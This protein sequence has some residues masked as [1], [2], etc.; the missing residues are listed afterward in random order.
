MSIEENNFYKSAVEK[1]DKED[2]QGVI[3][4]YSKAIQWIPSDQLKNTF[5]DVDLKHIKNY[6]NWI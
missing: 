3:H 6:P 1:F 5:M 4:D 2:S